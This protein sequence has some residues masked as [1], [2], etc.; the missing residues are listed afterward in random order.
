MSHIGVPQECYDHICN[1]LTGKTQIEYPFDGDAFHTRIWREGDKLMGEDPKGIREITVVRPDDMLNGTVGSLKGLF[2]QLLLQKGFNYEVII[3]LLCQ[4]K[5]EL[6]RLDAASRDK[7]NRNGA[8]TA[9]QQASKLFK[10]LVAVCE[11]QKEGVKISL[12]G[13]SFSAIL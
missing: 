3:S 10:T 2:T 4:I 5:P 12:S 1:E 6:D 9:K 7:S 8:E 11:K 13:P